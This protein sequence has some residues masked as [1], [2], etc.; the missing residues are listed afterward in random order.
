ML[1]AAASLRLAARRPRHPLMLTTGMRQV[2]IDG[3]SIKSMDDFYRIFAKEL[4]LPA[5]CGKDMDVLYDCLTRFMETPV[6]IFWMQS[7]VSRFFLDE[8]AGVIIKT[9]FEARKY[10]VYVHYL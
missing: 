10:G 1:Y 5:F 8:K 4:G 3:N 6:D 9:F 7:D 2:F